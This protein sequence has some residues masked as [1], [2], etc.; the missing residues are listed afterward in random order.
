MKQCVIFCAAGFEALIAP[1]TGSDRALV[2]VRAGGIACV[3]VAV[4]EAVVRRG[5]ARV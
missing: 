4:T 3:G 5:V 2:S 1:L